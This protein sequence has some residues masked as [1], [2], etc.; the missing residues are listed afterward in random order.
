MNFKYIV[1]ILGTIL[2][3]CCQDT[4]T[5]TKGPD[6]TVLVPLSVSAPATHS[7]S[8]APEAKD[9]IHSLHILVFTGNTTSLEQALLAYT[10]KATLQEGNK[11]IAGFVGSQDVHDL[12]RLVLLANA[13]D[14]KIGQLTQGSTYNQISETLYED[15]QQR[16]SPDAPVRMFGVVN[17][18]EGVQITENMSLETISLIRAV[19]RIDIGVGN[20]NEET[21]KW[22]LGPSDNYFQLT[23][24][25]VWSPMSRNSY[26]PAGG[27]FAYEVDG[28]PLVSSATSSLDY[29]AT[30]AVRWNY[31]GTDILSNNIATYCKDVIYLPETALQGYTAHQPLNSDKRTALIIGGILHNPTNPAAETKTWYRVDFMTAGG[32]TP[33]GE[34]FDLLRNH[35]YRISLNVSVAGAASAEEAWNI[36]MQPGQITVDVA[37]W[38]DGGVVD[39]PTDPSINIDKGNSTLPTGVDI[40]AADNRINVS[41]TGGVMW[42]AFRAETAVAVTKVVNPFPGRLQIDWDG[43]VQEAGDKIVTRFKVTVKEQTPGQEGYAVQIDLKSPLQGLSYNRFTIDVQPSDKLFATVTLGGRTWMAFNSGG[44]GNDAQFYLDPDVTV[45]DMYERRWVETLG[46][47]FQVGNNRAWVPWKQPNGTGAIYPYDWNGNPNGAP[48]P[49]GYCVPNMTELKALLPKKSLS[50]TNQE[51]YTYNGEKITAALKQGNPGTITFPETTIKGPTYYITLTSQE[52]GN[53]MYIP[54]GGWKMKNVA[55][56]NTK[57]GPRLL[58]NSGYASWGMTKKEWEMAWDYGREFLEGNDYY[59]YIRCVKK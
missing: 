10:V 31:T 12:Y 26:M 50:L 2:L 56:P 57:I 15:A 43:T 28:T 53:V 5:E 49:D 23:D 32:N 36:F 54:F 3:S 37:P 33:D 20:Y 39:V 11:F 22:V 14:T 40:A 7:S 6:K 35:L 46:S 1:F 19:A 59:A 44:K 9:A 4:L 30:T 17:R 8:T 41:N 18:G 55:D 51:V 16:Y 25:E 58:N 52:T 29:S 34:L 48:C 38:M 21:G 42:L 45:Q 27:K 13:D 24:V 47:Q